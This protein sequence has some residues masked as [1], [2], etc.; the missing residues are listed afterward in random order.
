MKTEKLISYYPKGIMLKK[1]GD[2]P[3][4]SYITFEE[5]IKKMKSKELKEQIKGVRKF[6]YKSWGYNNAKKRLPAAL[7]NKFKYN[8]NE[9]IIKENPIKPFDVD[10]TDNTETEIKRFKNEIKD[11][12]LFVM[13]SPSGKGL[14]FFIER[15]FNTL[16]PAIYIEKYKSMCKEIENEFNINLDYAQGRIKQ[17]FFLTYIN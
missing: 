11:K 5:L 4:T 14:K 7:F 15:A 1:G 12:A 3:P 16:D 6:E 2:N 17:P 9:G 13:D 10:L 8:L